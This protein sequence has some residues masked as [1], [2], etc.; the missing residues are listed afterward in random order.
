MSVKSSIGF[1]LYFY[2]KLP[3]YA[4]GGSLKMGVNIKSTLLP[5]TSK[6]LFQKLLLV[7]YY[8]ATNSSGFGLNTRPFFI[9]PESCKE[10]TPSL[11]CLKCVHSE[12]VWHFGFVYKLSMITALRGVMKTGHLRGG[13]P[14]PNWGGERGI[15]CA[16]HAQLVR[17]KVAICRPCA[18]GDTRM[19]SPL[20]SRHRPSSLAHAIATTKARAA[21]TDSWL[22]SHGGI[23]RGSHHQP[24]PASP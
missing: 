7:H 22:R 13:P 24:P 5:T 10:R 19:T 8:R 14:L 16:P 20:S 17:H 12:C 23:P 18:T 15:N 4:F 11:W 3:K 21:G 9:S 2:W 1:F 6:F